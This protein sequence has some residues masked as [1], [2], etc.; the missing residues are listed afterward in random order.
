MPPER[1]LGAASIA[2]QF[3]RR[4]VLG[5]RLNF[6]ARPVFCQTGQRFRT[7]FNRPGNYT[8]VTLAEADAAEAGECRTSG[9]W[10][11]ARSGAKPSRVE[12]AFRE[13]LAMWMR[14][15]EK[16]IEEL[17]PRSPLAQVLS[18]A[19]WLG[20]IRWRAGCPCHGHWLWKLA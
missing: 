5:I 17:G 16:S 8:G 12:S 19:K 11:T 20:L 3:L 15:L 4:G 6:G 2:T 9:D 7:F 10:P 13:S 14:L 18:K 1:L